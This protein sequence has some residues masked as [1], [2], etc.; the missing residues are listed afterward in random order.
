[1]VAATPAEILSRGV[2]TVVLKL[3][4]HGCAVYTPGREILSPAFEV[5]VRDTTGAG[6]CFVGGF[7]AAHSHGESLEGAARF[8]NAV[9][10]CSVQCV[11]ATKGVRG[12]AETERWMVSARRVAG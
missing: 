4:A 3:G 12:F 1:M 6:D 7:L 11:G 2:R 10:A 8:A 5:P 9:G